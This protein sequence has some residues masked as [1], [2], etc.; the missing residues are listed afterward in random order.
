MKYTLAR[1]NKQIGRRGTPAP[2]IKLNSGVEPTILA[3]LT[4]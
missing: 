4:V 3:N 1:N 2:L